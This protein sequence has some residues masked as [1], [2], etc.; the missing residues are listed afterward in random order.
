MKA[1]S[2]M[3]SLDNETDEC[4][5]KLCRELSAG[6]SRGHTGRK[7]KIRE[8]GQRNWYDYTKEIPTKTN[9]PL[10]SSSTV[11]WIKC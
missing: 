5:T 11:D 10:R 4:M 1:K 6:L 3:V 2:S 7:E 9:I 8:H